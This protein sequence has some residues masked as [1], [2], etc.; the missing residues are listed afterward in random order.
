MRSVGKATIIDCIKLSALIVAGQAMIL[1]PA[2]AGGPVSHAGICR[3][4]AAAHPA[5]LAVDDMVESGD[6][7]LNG[8]G[9]IEHVT[10]G[11]ADG[12]MRRGTFDVVDGHGARHKIAVPL[13]ETGGGLAGRWFVASRRGYLVTFADED[14]KYIG[15]LF[16]ISRAYEPHLLCA[17]KNDVRRNLLPLRPEDK[18]ICEAS[19]ADL[20]PDPA[21]PAKMPETKGW[22]FTNGALLG[23]AIDAAFDNAGTGTKIAPVAVDS[24]AGRGC[25]YDYFQLAGDDDSAAARHQ[26]ELLEALQERGAYSGNSPSCPANR[27]SWFTYAGKT[28]LRSRPSNVRISEKFDRADRVNGVVDGVPRRICS[29]FYQVTW[30]LVK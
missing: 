23:P 14:E 25:S 29:A 28:F 15:G 22:R 10:P 16:E 2:A 6:F 20:P 17:F 1:T 30:T 24:G 11:D 19:D 7:D 27:L 8:D 9:K 26:R 21:V 12:T 4:F 18:P 3:S 13:Y 5:H